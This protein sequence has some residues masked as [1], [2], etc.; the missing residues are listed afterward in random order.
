M[1]LSGISLR[2]VVFQNL[3]DAP[4]VTWNGDFG[5]REGGSYK[6]A[7]ANFNMNKASPIL[8]E[9]YFRSLT[10]LEILNEGKT[11]GPDNFE[12]LLQISGMEHLNLSSTQNIGVDDRLVVKM[13]SAWPQLESFRVFAA[14]LASRQTL[15]AIQTF[16]RHCPNSAAS[17]WDPQVTQFSDF[18][19]IHPLE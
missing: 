3:E 9:C 6:Q 19:T 12:A 7:I 10:K 4:S 15:A 8:G 5:E 11:F 2:S 1:K 16:A 17:L 18:Q 14:P 13:A